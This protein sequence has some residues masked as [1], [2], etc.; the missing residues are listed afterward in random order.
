MGRSPG[1]SI[2]RLAGLGFA[3]AAAAAASVSIA[4]PAAAAE[5]Q[6]LHAGSANAIDG[7]YI[8]VFKDAVS[9][10]GVQARANDTAAKYGGQVKHTYTA[11]L[12]GYA[13]SM[14]E[15]QA[16]RAA[17]D[18]AVAYVEQDQVMRIADTQPNPPS[19]GL[20][21][22]DQR[23]LPMNSSYTYPTTASNV[24]AYIVDTGIRTTHNDFG[25]RANWGTNTTGDGNNSDCN[26]HG[27][28]V[29]GT[30][31]G[32]AHG[33]AKGVR[34]V[35]VKVLGCTGSGSNTGVIAGVDFVTQNH[36]SGPASANMSLGGGASTALDNAVRNSIADGVTYAIASGNS[37]VSACNSSPARVAEAIT[38]NASTTSDSRASFSNFGTCT[39]IFAP[40]QGITSA[41]STSNTAT[42]TISGT[43][44]ATP[45]V[46]GAAAL[47]LSS[48][49]GATPAQVANGL[50]AASTPNKITNPGSGSPNRLLFVGSGGT[51]PPP[52]PC[53]A[54][55]NGNDVAIPDLSTVSSSITIS[56]CTGNASGTSSIEVHI[57]HTYIGDLVVD[58]IAPDGSVYNLHNRAGG[59]ANDI[60]QTYTRNLSSES[61]NGTWTLRVRDAAAIDVG[62][63]DSWTLDL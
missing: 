31:G 22:I 37:N 45:H 46:A 19:W 8:V 43:S 17:A 9:A 16:K 62:R 34:L 36:T 4:M 59:S 38:V 5:G 13:A 18:P 33:V 30:V 26:G 20:D 1:R 6:I 40:G 27:T 39:D 42:N 52:G 23:D 3:A 35:A 54:A 25:G 49:T 57:V 14:T 21:R 44:M 51:T 2:R 53:P 47:F 12:H 63:I 7:S 29:A 61:A 56:G 32:T 41:W 60:N 11:A 48:N 10:Q 55:T 50:F 58:L 28:H 15:Q 24:T